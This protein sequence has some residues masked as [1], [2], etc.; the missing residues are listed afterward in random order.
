ML[1]N[2][3][4]RVAKKAL[5][6]LAEVL[7]NGLEDPEQGFETECITPEYL[8]LI[9]GMFAAVHG[10]PGRPCLFDA[11]N[12]PGLYRIALQCGASQSQDFDKLDDLWVIVAKTA[13]SAS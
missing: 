9:A 7:R 10:A 5:E 11:W 3:P 6:A 1:Y 13:E 2:E 4:T 12:G 8:A